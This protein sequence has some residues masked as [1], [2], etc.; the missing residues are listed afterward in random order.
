MARSTDDL[1]DYQRY[2]QQWSDICMLRLFDSFM[3]SAPQLLFQLYVM[4]TSEKWSAWTGISAVASC[5]SLGWGVAAYSQA[6]RLVREDKSELSWTGM[7]LQTT[8][9]FFML[10]ARITAM[11]LLCLAIGKWAIIVF[12]IHW[13]VM[14]AWVL[15]QDTDFCTNAWEERLYNAVVGV[16]YCFCFFNLKEGRSRYRMA[17]FYTIT[18]I[19]NI[20]F[21]AVYY[22]L[23][24]CQENQLDVEPDLFSLMAMSTVV[25]GFVVGL[26]SMVLYY[27]FH[28]PAGPIPCCS[29]GEEDRAE[30]VGRK[31]DSE[32]PDFVIKDATY[33]EDK[34][35]S[36]PEKPPRDVNRSN[37]LKHSRSVKCA[38]KRPPASPPRLMSVDTMR[39][40]NRQLATPVSS[41]RV[42]EVI[43]S[44]HKLSTSTPVA[45]P[46]T[47][48]LRPPS[49]E[50]AK[51]SERL[52]SAYGTDSNR[53][54]SRNTESSGLA[55]GK[56]PT[57][58]YVPHNL[59]NQSNSPNNPNHSG[60]SGSSVAFNNETY[61]SIEASSSGGQDGTY[62]DLASPCSGGLEENS[63]NNTYQSVHPPTADTTRS[64]ANTSQESSTSRVTVVDQATKPAP[65]RQDVLLK[66]SPVLRDVTVG[67][68]SPVKENNKSESPTSPE[69][70]KLHA[71]LTIII[72][73][74]SN[75]A[76]T[77]SSSSSQSPDKWSEK[78]ISLDILNPETGPPDI[79]GFSSHDYENLALVNIN[80]APL[81]PMHWR[82]YS[83]MANSR[84]DDSTKYDK[85]KLN[86]TSSSNYSDYSNFAFCDIYP[87]SKE[88]KGKLYRSL[89]PVSTAATMATSL[90]R[91]E[92][93]ESNHTYEPIE[94]A[95]QAFSS[96]GEYRPSSSQIPVTLIHHD[97]RRV[98]ANTI[99]NL[100][101]LREVLHQHEQIPYE[102]PENR[103][104]L[105]LLAPMRLLTPIGEETESDI[106]GRS[107]T[108]QALST[109]SKEYSDVDQS[110]M[111]IISE[112]LNARGSDAMPRSVSQSVQQP[113]TSDAVDTNS[114]LST[115]EE[116]R[117]NSMCNLYYNGDKA[118]AQPSLVPRVPPRH[119]S[120]Y[121][122]LCAENNKSRTS[123][124]LDPNDI[125]KVK[126]NVQDST[127]TKESTEHND[128]IKSVNSNT[129]V[130]TPT[131]VRAAVKRQSP[132]QT[133]RG[134]RKNILNL[135]GSTSDIL[136]TPKRVKTEALSVPS[137]GDT[138]SDSLAT[139]NN[140]FKALMP[141][142]TFS[143]AKFLHKVK[144]SPTLDDSSELDQPQQETARPDPRLRLV[145]HS[146]PDV[147]R[148]SGLSE[149]PSPA[150]FVRNI[151]NQ[152]KPKRKLSIVR[153]KVERIQ[154]DD[155][156]D[157]KYG[158]MKRNPDAKY[159]F[160]YYPSESYTVVETA[161][162]C[163]TSSSSTYRAF[164]SGISHS[165]PQP[166]SRLQPSFPASAL[167]HV[168]SLSALN[169]GD[170]V[171][172]LK[173]DETY[174]NLQ[175]NNWGSASL[176]RR[177]SKS[178]LEEKHL[179]RDVSS[180]RSMSI[181]DGFNDEKENIIPRRCPAEPVRSNPVKVLGA[182]QSG[183]S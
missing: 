178:A 60:S 57:G 134:C 154:H 51:V 1:V 104:D 107:K 59:H 155:D 142:L 89:T 38:A 92:S 26:C 172:K 111:S 43:Y 88:M 166:L 75:Q 46:L 58:S 96:D 141:H 175:R 121:E 161:K 118:V 100:D 83:D 56:S 17:I 32:G 120:G 106:T 2:Y 55:L 21:M 36:P 164:T 125:Q 6:L 18:F 128:S 138:L 101:N 47:P 162:L 129:L 169:K 4:C 139:E 68:S 181:L 127:L 29:K 65:G 157:Y 133:S 149:T 70:A 53:T 84:H 14:A 80:R 99:V 87:L 168:Y 9:R 112:V 119:T 156:S 86:F 39:R 74:I 131:T 152:T 81:G 62:M 5:V 91:S 61:M 179:V 10:V 69:K 25:V 153:E 123:L 150:Q 126:T 160:G 148:I 63:P 19:E 76:F 146:T 94:T 15:W 174:E 159:G 7:A 52:D 143:G 167:S 103:G 95:G 145:H 114:L 102:D 24:F 77:K 140:E 110:I 130:V 12:L 82:T 31:E 90:D 40:T 72:P 79:S 108:Y 54:A 124:R 144:K 163:T 105:Y 71:P 41:P 170:T 33:V 93:G 109:Q 147:S 116:I 115:I 44:P 182:R 8:W 67:V 151:G 48:A 158:F 183:R 34:D 13:L 137:G 49:E 122:S 50:S 180:R 16:I 66:R 3:E 173:P 37:S 132:L 97:G 27:R 20:S 136:N 22:V 117:N 23:K 113:L 85:V 177:P 98:T 78:T 11:L 30:K 45:A 42:E 171:F 73:N 64:D 176:Q 28:H 165:D 135:V 35:T